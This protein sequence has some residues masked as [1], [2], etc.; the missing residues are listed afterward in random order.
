MQVKKLMVG[1]KQTM[2]WPE[3]L[4]LK[5]SEKPCETILE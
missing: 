3:G 5:P 1:F 4:Q 2:L